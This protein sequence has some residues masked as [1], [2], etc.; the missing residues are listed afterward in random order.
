MALDTN[1]AEL[2]SLLSREGA[3]RR[4]RLP[5]SST[6]VLQRQGRNTA[7]LFT[8]AKGV[9]ENWGW[10]PTGIS[11]EDIIYISFP[12]MPE[13]IELARD[14]TYKHHQ[15]PTHPDGFHIY[16]SMGFLEIPISFELHAHDTEYC[17][18]QGPVALLTIAAKLH[19]M[20]MPIVRNQFAGQFTLTLKEAEGGKPAE[21]G[22][23]IVDPQSNDAS[24]LQLRFPPPCV[25]NI[26]LG[27]EGQGQLGGIGICCRGF[28]KRVSVKL[29]GPWLN[30]PRFHRNLPSRAEYE[31]TFVHNPSYSNAL[32]YSSEGGNKDIYGKSRQ[33]TFIGSQQSD[34][35][36][37]S[38]FN[39]LGVVNEE[40][41][42]EQQGLS[43]AGGNISSQVTPP[44]KGEQVPKDAALDEFGFP[45]TL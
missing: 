2:E 32:Y 8:L 7:R 20:Q 17:G 43:N 27:N 28:I 45:V 22:N 1:N 16:Q 19:A 44:K 34:L 39:S 9:G 6:A 18:D 12:A 37:S 36:L 4:A 24:A 35:V 21:F 14:V 11:T 26:I 13:V 10:F 29:H 25:M 5:A 41:L 3:L 42:T 30:Y 23:T 38:L 31:F 15:I 40:S 33:T